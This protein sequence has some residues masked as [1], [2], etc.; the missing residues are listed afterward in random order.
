[1]AASRQPDATRADTMLRT[2]PVVWLSTVR[3]DGLPHLVPIWFWWDGES[4]L[5]ASKP[6]ARKVANLRENPS[7]MLAVGDPEADFDVSLIEARAE[8]TSIPTSWLLQAG[9]YDKYGDQM[10]SI[11][12]DR[13]EF[14][15][16]YSQVIRITPTRWLP[17]HGRTEP[18][19]PGPAAAALAVA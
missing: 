1:M 5:I 9:L 8:L 3:P 10:R 11:G 2:E 15:A 7:A 18:R 6:H 14:A 12:L 17:W 19:Q 13:A 4:V 16:T